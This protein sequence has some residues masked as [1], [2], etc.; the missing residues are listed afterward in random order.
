[1]PELPEV[2]TVVRGLKTATAGLTIHNVSVVDPKLDHLLRDESPRGARIEDV[3]RHGKFLALILNG[4]R[5]LLMHM[6]MSGRI[7][8]RSREHAPDPYLR[9]SLDLD[10]HL[11]IRFCDP[12]RFGTARLLESDGYR[13]FKSRLGMEPFS[14]AFTT[15]NLVKALA[16][17]RTAIKTALMNQSIVAGVGNIY[18]DEA[19][20]RARLN[21]LTAAGEL[22]RNEVTKLVRSVRKVLRDGIEAGGTTF[23]RYTNADGDP[24][25]NQV[26][27]N[28]FR[29]SSK[30]CRRCSTTIVKTIAGGRSTHYCPVC[31]PT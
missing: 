17:R 20:W 11:Q 14:E 10:G 8:V 29:R 23:G 5:V 18:A 13:R 9:L 15:A 26:N 1:M 31:Q 6:M 12:R 24:G 27:L 21:P 16:G 3:R 22:N 2:E 28:V 30:P 25:M 19:L 7:L 4:D